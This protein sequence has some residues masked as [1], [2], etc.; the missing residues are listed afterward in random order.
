MEHDIVLKYLRVPHRGIVNTERTLFKGTFSQMLDLVG[1]TLRKNTTGQ[2]E[3]LLS[4]LVLSVVWF[5]MFN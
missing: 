1:S 2:S 5:L 3:N 4:P